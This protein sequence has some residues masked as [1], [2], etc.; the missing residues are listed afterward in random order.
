MVRLAPLL[1]AASLVVPLPGFH[2]PSGNITCFFIPH[3]PTLL[4]QIR[5]ASYATSLQKTCLMPSGAGVDWHGFI[6]GPAKPGMVN[7]SGGSLYSPETQRPV[8]VNQP[9]GTTWRHGTYACASRVTGVTCTNAH[10]HGIFV[11][12]ASWRVW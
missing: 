3:G 4:C 10:G 9:Y 1:A 8:L 5:Q 6:L 12:R 7:C 2:S 11:S